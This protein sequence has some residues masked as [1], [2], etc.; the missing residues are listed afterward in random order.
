MVT[1]KMSNV[2]DLEQGVMCMDLPYSL[3]R[4]WRESQI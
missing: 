4:C 3:Y 2:L 1:V